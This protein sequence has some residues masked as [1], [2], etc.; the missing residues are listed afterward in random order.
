MYIPRVQ[1]T[2]F[3]SRSLPPWCLEC[4]LD[5]SLSPDPKQRRTVCGVHWEENAMFGFFRKL[6]A[7]TQILSPPYCASYLMWEILTVHFHN[8]ARRELFTR[9]MRRPRYKWFKEPTSRLSS[10]YILGLASDPSLQSFKA[11]ILSIDCAALV[12][13][14][15][16]HRILGGVLQG[17]SFHI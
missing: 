3:L 15:G 11:H 13:V 14:L 12:I 16:Y 2:G 10:K 1:A 4:C 8:S 5:V 9:Q 7:F 6:P 17:L